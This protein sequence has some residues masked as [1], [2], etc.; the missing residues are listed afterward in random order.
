MFCSN[1]TIFKEQV[2]SF[3]RN[4]FLS[5]F[6][7]S[8]H[9]A[10]AAAVLLVHVVPSGDKDCHTSEAIAGSGMEAPVFSLPVALPSTLKYYGSPCVAFGFFIWP[11]LCCQ[12]GM[13]FAHSQ[14]NSQP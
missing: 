7:S 4:R 14:P 2:V 13:N 1:G 8:N 5:F 3:D 10:I 6:A 9:C 12:R 11:V